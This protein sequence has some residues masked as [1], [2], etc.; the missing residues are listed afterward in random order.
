MYKRFF[1]RVFDIFISIVLLVISSPLLILVSAVLM[2]VNKGKVFFLQHRPGYKGIPF[3]LIK[4]QTLKELKGPNG[5]SLPDEFRITR[6]GSFI[7]S[8]SIDEL[9]QL[10]NVLKGD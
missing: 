2:F 5:K 3:L 8:T 6:L 1:K 4:L 9:P 7:R 10:I